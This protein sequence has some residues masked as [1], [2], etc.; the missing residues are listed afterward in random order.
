MFMLMTAA[1]VPLQRMLRSQYK[2][3][4]T[5]ATGDGKSEQ[6]HFSVLPR[7]LPLGQLIHLQC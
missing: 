3:A 5:A 2:A 7:P 1:G 4:A 6:V